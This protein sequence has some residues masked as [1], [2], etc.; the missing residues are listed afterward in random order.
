MTILIAAAISLVVSIRTAPSDVAQAA[1]LET[2]SVWKPAGVELAWDIDDPTHHSTVMPELYVIVTD[3]CAHESAEHTSLASIT[4]VH[5]VP[6]HRIVVCYGH[7]AQ[8]LSQSRL[9][10][11]VTPRALQNEL[12]ARVLGRAVAHEIGHYLLGPSHSGHG[13]MRAVHS[14][15]ELCAESPRNFALSDVE[16]S[17]A[18]AVLRQ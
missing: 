2:A 13:L 12:P 6:Q 11:A 15:D 14:L 18:R 5:G 9:D 16:R 3:R 8:L 10:W 4:F 7:I 17:A 1:M